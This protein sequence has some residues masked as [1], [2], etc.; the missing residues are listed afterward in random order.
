MRQLERAGKM[1]LVREPGRHRGIDQRFTSFNQTAGQ[2][3]AL[4]ANER[5]RREPGYLLE[6]TDHLETGDA[7][8]FGKASELE[9][10]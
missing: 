6:V 7:S 8:G 9:P 3:D 5:A 10:S 2:L 1:T 4:V